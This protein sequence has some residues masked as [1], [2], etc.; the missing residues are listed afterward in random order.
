M[1][2]TDVQTAPDPDAIRLRI[3]R[4]DGPAQA[5]LK[6]AEELIK[7]MSQGKD[8][9]SK[10]IAKKIV[11]GANQVIAVLE[12]V[13][14][15]HPVA[16]AVVTVF[17]AI[18]TLELDRRD[19]N[20]QI[21]AICHSMTRMMHVIRYLADVIEEEDALKEAFE[22]DFGAIEALMKE[23]G[24]FS[25]VYYKYRQSTF[26]LCFS[27]SYKERL[28][29]FASQF[30]EKKQ[31][32]ESL[33]SYRTTITV[34][35]THG[36]VVGISDD[37]QKV[38]SMLGEMTEKE[39]KAM[40][41]IAQHGG[42]E[43][44]VENDASLVALAN[45]LGDKLNGPL[46]KA[47][48]EDLD[49]LLEDNHVQSSMKIDGATMQI[50]E[51]VLASK[52]AILRRLDA[53][54]HELIEDED[55]RKVWQAL[56]D[57]F[58]LKFRESKITTG[59]DHPD[60]WTLEILSKVMFHG[61]IGDAID[62]DGSGFLSV[63]EVNEFLRACPANWTVP[64]WLAFWAVGWLDNNIRYYDDILELLETI[65]KAAK[66]SLEANKENMAEYLE[67]LEFVQPI[68]MDSIEDGADENYEPGD[69]GFE[70][71]DRLQDE[72]RRLERD[73]ITKN[74]VPVDWTLDDEHTL[75][76][77]TKDLNKGQR[78]ELSI[79]ALLTLLL[80]HHRDIVVSTQKE[81]VDEDKFW[82]MGETL[83]T[84]FYTFNDRM[85]DLIRG[86][87]QQRKEVSLQINCFAGGLYSGWHAEVEKPNNALSRLR[88]LWDDD[89]DDDSSDDGEDDAPEPD[90]MEQLVG[91]VASLE[92]KL[93]NIEGLLRSLIDSR[94]APSSARAPPQGTSPRQM[95][96][97]RSK[98]TR[99]PTNHS[100]NE[101]ANDNPDEKEN[102]DSDHEEESRDDG[103][104]DDNDDE[105]A[106]GGDADDDNDDND[107][108]NDDN[109]DD[110]D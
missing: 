83:L 1:S 44:V 76:S 47:I 106:Q 25:G 20:E 67:I 8:K 28:S 14:E 15:I 68:I 42:P 35:A 34:Q 9:D 27:G 58:E 40:S 102:D 69:D 108:D 6:S 2:V 32:L 59:L 3:E 65:Q 66:S 5:S 101:D 39:K 74:L 92:T 41:Y 11:S 70:E 64:Q 103:G 105:S 60:K 7:R 30:S 19:N 24:E 54:P 110:E 10:K 17:K 45:I 100:D 98:G 57:H 94:G 55:V 13:S 52:D 89:S 37:I 88:K 96:A 81:V 53:G 36:Q 31:A 79:M 91:R 50:T 77:A 29:G 86:W 56:H 63:R 78:I 90:K 62:A 97:R 72:F 71:L 85:V 84:V 48:R 87:K 18:I 93:A 95:D 109:D 12:G 51:E 38:I 33:L 75:I 46:K 82:A 61:A 73:R 43:A 23:F 16:K 22:E 4:L 104:D 99:V 26:R 107:N 80:E 21:A 49:Q